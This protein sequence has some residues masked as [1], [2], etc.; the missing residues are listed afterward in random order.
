MTYLLNYNKGPELGA[1]KLILLQNEKERT[2]EGLPKHFPKLKF[3]DTRPFSTAARLV[4]AGFSPKIVGA[5]VELFYR[6]TRQNC[7]VK[8]FVTNSRKTTQE[9]S[10]FGI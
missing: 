10:E 2:S 1:Y 6:T 4:E 5:S 8:E 7:F 3:L 9:K